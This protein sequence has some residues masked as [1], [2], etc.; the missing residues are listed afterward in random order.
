[1]KIYIIGSSGAI[2]YP[3]FNF[4]KKKIN[5][6][7]TYHKNKKPGLIKFSLGNEFSENRLLQKIKPE[8][9]VF[10]LSSYT[11]VPWIVKNKKKSKNLN[12]FS[13]KKFLAKLIR[14]KINF[15][16]FSS[17]EVFNG[18]RGYYNEKSRTI[19][20]NYYGKLKFRIE[21]YL[22]KTRYSNYHVI[23]LGRIVEF[24]KSYPCMIEDCYNVLLKP[25]A[26][27]AVDNLFTI[28]HVNDFNKAIYKVIKKKKLPKILHIC[29]GHAISRTRF[30]DLIIDASTKSNLMHYTKCK[31]KD[32]K[33]NE[34]RAAKNNLD[35]S[36]TSKLLNVK[37]TKPKKII[38]EKIKIIE[39]KN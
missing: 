38:F 34:K 15:Y 11:S 33:Y 35:S 4:L 36:F 37:Y 19:P 25:K 22:N 6:L 8:D 30:A 29:S 2:G 1:M 12:F 39:K 20:V 18:K 28:T 13:T 32:I 21:K 7:G 24:T 27:M 17:A 26:K 3:L 23:R 16:Y 5:V 10:F 9:K 14:N 31:F